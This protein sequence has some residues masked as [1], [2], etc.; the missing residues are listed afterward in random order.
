ME[1]CQLGHRWSG[2][3][4]NYELGPCVESSRRAT[5]KREAS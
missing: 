4:K 3:E 1:M 2:A 5:K